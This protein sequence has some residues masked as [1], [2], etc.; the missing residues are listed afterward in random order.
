MSTSRKEICYKKLSYETLFLI[1]QLVKSLEYSNTFNEENSEKLNLVSS[2]I[3]NII[4]LCT[5][6]QK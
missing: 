6:N 4:E 5:K 2:K 3:D 1:H